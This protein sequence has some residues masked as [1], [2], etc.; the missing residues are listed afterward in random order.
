MPGEAYGGSHRAWG[1]GSK[2]GKLLQPLQAP[3]LLKSR[4]TAKPTMS[5]QGTAAKSGLR[6]VFRRTRGDAELPIW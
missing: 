1:K 6:L 4:R 2:G 5:Q 3:F